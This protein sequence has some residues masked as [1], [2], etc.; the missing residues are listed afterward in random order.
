MFLIRA[1]PIWLLL[2]FVCLPV[3]AQK[4]NFNK[5]KVVKKNYYTEVAYTELK[6]KIIIPVKIQ[7]QTYRFLFDTGAPNLISHSLIDIIQTKTLQTVQVKD[8]NDKRRPLKVVLIPMLDIGGV[9]FK[10]SP[11]IVN[12]SDSSF[13]FDCLNIDGIIGSNL[14]RNS[15]VQIDASKKQFI[16][17]DQA[18]KLNLENLASLDMALNSNQSSPYI[19]IKLKG[20]GKASEQVLLDTGAEGFYDLSINSYKK[21]KELQVFSHIDSA[22][23]YKGVGLFGVSEASTYY[24]VQLPSIDFLGAAFENVISISTAASKSRIG[25]DLFRFGKAT[26][27]F[28]KKK[29][30]FEC[31]EKRFDLQEEVWP[32]SPTVKNG[33]VVVGIVWDEELSSNLKFGTRIIKINDLDIPSMQICDLLVKTSPLKDHDEL[34]MV[35]QDASGKAIEITLENY[36]LEP[37]IVKVE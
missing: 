29:F 19:W 3:F 9:H 22:Q 26:L 37:N 10:N 35:V 31:Y 36:Y 28:K 27:N 30:Y 14:V 34:K 20:E 2:L 32:F 8:A 33:E 12:D 11:A 24:R 18:Q 5:G 17:T 25:A 1:T 15:I 7:G 21:L 16:L 4:V 23:G 6:N 13:L